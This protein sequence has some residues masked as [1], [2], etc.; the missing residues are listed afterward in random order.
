M[1]R[2]FASP[3]VCVLF[4]L[5][6]LGSPLAGQGFFSQ[7]R[8]PDDSALDLSA[9]LATSYGFLPAVMPITEP[10]VGMGAG[11]ALAFLHRPKG[12]DID[13]ARA[14]FEAGERLTAPSV[15]AVYGMYTASNSWVAG[16]A[17]I[18]N[19]KNGRWRYLGNASILRLNL[20]MAGRLP[21]GRE[22]LF[23]YGLDG[24]AVTQSLR[25]RLGASDWLV[26]AVFD[27][28]QMN[29]LFSG[30][31]LPG[32]DPLELDASLSGLGF[33]I[34]YDSRNSTFTP[35]R[36]VFVDVEVKR[37]DELLGSDFEYWST[38]AVFHGHLNPTKRMVLGV[39]VE[40]A[41]AGQEAPFWAR[42]SVNLR[43]VAR[44]RYP[45]DRAG[46]IESEVR[47]DLSRRWSLVG[48]GGAGWTSTE[49]GE[50]VDRWLGGGGGGFR[51]LVARA[52]GIRGGVDVAYGYDGWAVYFT[53]GS[54]WPSF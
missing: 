43:G 10:A 54:A 38:K 48:F 31:S 28:M 44:G 30:E 35:D 23:D 46:V 51:Y 29:T 2:F 8:D 1:T 5:T 26:G 19:W 53:T 50:G 13:E 42:P 9:F 47:F 17:H 27:Y 18:G 34:R 24:W 15:S 12:W 21:D 7:F 39:R 3:A 49:G 14:A 45:G 25:H 22:V 16:A 37:R 40:G 6:L 41:T 11:A 4:L 33:A 32:V 20:S 36:G 52:F